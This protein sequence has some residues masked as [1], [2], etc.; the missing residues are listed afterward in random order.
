[1]FSYKR[2][3]LWTFCFLTLSRS[4]RKLNWS[5]AKMPS[6]GLTRKKY[7]NPRSVSVGE[8][9]SEHTYGIPSRSVAWLAVFV[10]EL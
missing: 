3:T 9:E 7:F 8:E 2:A 4:F 1:M 10:T 5:W 6:W